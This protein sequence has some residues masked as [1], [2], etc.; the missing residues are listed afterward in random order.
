MIKSLNLAVSGIK[1]DLNKNSIMIHS[2]ME[3]E[4]A[5]LSKVF[6]ELLN[7]VQLM[8]VNQAFEKSL[9]LIFHNS[10]IYLWIY[11]QK[12]N[13]YYS[14]TLSRSLPTDGGLLSCSAREKEVQ[15]AD[16]AS[17]HNSYN[18]HFDGYI[19]P[20]DFPIIIIPLMNK[21]RIIYGVVQIIRSSPFF[22]ENE[23]KNANN[24]C[25]RF[26]SYCRLIFNFETC[27]TTAQSLVGVDQ[28][29][30]ILGKVSASLCKF[31]KC[32]KVEFYMKRLNDNLI[33]KLD[34]GSN[35]LVPMK[36]GEIGVISKCISE[37]VIVNERLTKR[38]KCFKVDSDDSVDLPV[39][40]VPFSNDEDKIWAICL[41]GKTN[42][43][44][45][46]QTDE[47][48]LL[49]LAPFA[50]K[51]LA[52]SL[53]P[54]S[55]LPQLNDFEK[56]LTVLLEVAETLSGV[57]D[58]ETL[59]PTIMERACQL[60]H[61][62]RCSLFLVDKVKNE[63]ETRFAGGLSKSLRI[64]LSRGI[65]G[66]TAVTGNIVNIKNAY[67]D[68]RFDRSIDVTT[69]Y[70]TVSLLTV[71]IYNNRGEITGV[72][73]MINKTDSDCFSE[74]DVRM[75]MAFNVFCGISLD[76]ARLYKASLDLTRQL[77]TFTEMT[78]ALGKTKTLNSVLEEILEN[79][80][81]VV[82]GSRGS[83]YLYHSNDR[84]L[85]EVVSVGDHNM[86]GDILAKTIVTKRKSHVFNEKELAEL[87]QSSHLE[88]AIEKLILET[89]SLQ[90]F[91][92]PK[93]SGSSIPATLGSIDSQL[94]VG[95][96]QN[97]QNNIG[98]Y[99]SESKYVIG[100]PL[101]DSSQILLGVM[102]IACK[103]KVVPDDMRLLDC[104]AV[105]ASVS[106]ERSNLKD[107]AEHGHIE[108]ELKQWFADD[109]ERKA[110]GKD[111]PS[112]LKIPKEHLEGIWTI[113]FDAPAWDGIGHFKVLFSIFNRFNLLEEFNISN[114]KFF[115][116]LSAIEKTYKKVPYHNWRH[117][118][119]VTQFVTYE[120]IISG[121]DKVF[122]RFEIFGLLV[123]AIC[124]DANHDGFTN[125]YNVKAETPLGILYQNQSVMET[126]HCA[127]AIDVI[128]KE[129]TNI[130]SSL[131]PAEYKKLWTLI[132]D[133]ILITDMAKHFAIVKEVNALH[134]E[135]MWDP[136]NNPKHKL[137]LMQLIL[138]CGD[139]SNVS[140]PFELADKW[141]DVL[142]EE[143]F[144]QG[145]LEMAQ[146]MQYTSDLNDRA[147]LNKPKSQIGFYMFVCLPLYTV[148]ARCI[149]S[150]QV[151]VDQIN[152]NLAIWK[153]AKEE[154]ERLAAEAE[155]NENRNPNENHV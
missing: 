32:I 125:I 100:I 115:R 42:Q 41:R 86:Y 47:N 131:N 58:I 72:T 87:T 25:A 60:L 90:D 65:V 102:E 95:M 92:S 55:D 49:A 20:P 104:F 117:A 85:N 24:F 130:F 136:N 108:V 34:E 106:I 70:K 121:Y 38:N 7:N 28:L 122:T 155:K 119:D 43:S 124:H 18:Q 15:C 26:K 73:E 37:R 48:V 134:D 31:F 52:T 44:Y 96:G 138:K 79:A 46:T 103:W 81:S 6:D 3:Y 91:P 30:K 56:K 140:R 144:R 150:L 50:I 110:C 152:S 132:I 151:N 61:A 22:S 54:S 68:S 71:P 29:Q 62:Q 5:P 101:M 126:H 69:G 19:I 67:E 105:L 118:V 9:R 114:E 40:I 66:H 146:G 64:P 76:N 57:L 53:F 137:I 120:L 8:S 27:L 143:F 145:D 135:G 94:N 83:L 21:S 1:N 139:I 36:V 11:F 84:Q 23:Q 13:L 82:S 12:E 45:F 33:Y 109:N 149:P 113:N 127:I 75:L 88:S 39:L 142:C 10:D 111:V 14:P 116:F 59:I 17:S 98:A 123:A 74:E 112:K 77:R 99:N 107:I 51:S 97:S 129:E 80:R 16:R 133:L 35:T 147:H 93:S 154:E 153:A 148:C 89:P 63:L 128:S 2:K 78:A 141:C 4:K